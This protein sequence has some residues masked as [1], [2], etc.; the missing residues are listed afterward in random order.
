MY[1][2][3]CACVCVRVCRCVRVYDVCLYK[4]DIRQCARETRITE[5]HTRSRKLKDETIHGN[6]GSYFS[7]RSGENRCLTDLSNVSFGL[8]WSVCSL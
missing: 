8:S 2:C 6:N 4:Y 1:V 5:K 7:I 3:V